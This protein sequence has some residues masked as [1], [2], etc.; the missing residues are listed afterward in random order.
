MGQITTGIGLISGINTADIIDQL[1]A[2][3][4][5]PKELVQQQNA[6]LTAQ[7]AAFQSISARLLGL[8]LSVGTLASTDIFGS[9]AASSSNESVITASSTNSAVPGSYS[10]TVDRLVSTQ[11]V[12]TNGFVDQN[13]TPIVTSGGT[14]TFEFGDARLDSNR[15]LSQLNG[16]NGIQRG[17]ISIT[18]RNGDTAVVDLSK[19]L[20]LNDVLDAIN[21]TAGIDVTASAD[22]DSFKLTDTSGGG[23]SLSVTDAGPHA[24]TASL[25]L[26][27][28]A[29]GDALTGTAVNI[30]G[31]DLFLGALNDNNG[32]RIRT[33]L[34][35]LQITRRDGTTFNVNLDGVAD[36]GGVIDTINA[37]S[38][39]DVT[40]SITSDGK[41][42]QLVDTTG[43]TSSNLQVAAI[44]GSLA[45]NDLGLVMS[46]A[47]NTLVGNRPMAELGSRLIKNLNGGSGVTT[48]GTIDLTNRTGATLV[49]LDLSSAQSVSDIIT[50]INNAGHSITASFNT[51]RNGVILTDTTGSTA[52]NL[53][54]A[55]NVGT[56]AT[57]L[58]LA[59]SVAATTIDSGNLQLRY[60]SEATTLAS[61]NGG[62][63]VASG[64]FTITDSSG[65]VATVD[66][67]QGD[68]TT[69]Q[70]VISEIN[71]RGLAINAR[72]NDNGDGILIEDTGT[73]VVKLK[74]EEFGSSTAKDL[75][76]L[77][78]ATILGADLDGSFEKTVS[79]A[80]VQT[81]TGTTTLSSLNGGTGVNAEAG[82]DDLRFTVQDGTTYDLNLDGLTTITDLINAIST[83]TSGAVTATIDALETGLT[84]TDSTSGAATFKVEALNSSQGGSDLDI[85]K[86]DDDGN[87]I[88]SGGA[89]VEI[90]TL[91][92][93]VGKINDLGI[94]INATVINDGSSISPFRLS[95]QGAVAGE[96]GRFMFD[97]G[98][99]GFGASTL[100]EAQNAV[101]FF[102]S[103]DPA[104]A[105]AITSANNTLTSIVP[106]ATIDL[107][108][109]SDS[110]VTVTI[111]RDDGA[112]VSAAENFVSSF[113]DLVTTLDDL[114]SYEIETEVRGIL[115]GD[116]TVAN[117]RS[118]LFRLVNGK[119]ND[120]TSQFTALT[121]IGL[122]IS[123]G[124]QMRFDETKFRNALSTDFSALEQLFTFK[125]TVTDP[126][127]LEVTLTAGGIMVRFED[128][129]EK[130]N[131]TTSGTIQNRFDSIQ[132]QID[133]GNQ[134]I[135]QFDIQLQSKRERLEFEFLSMELALAQLQ[136]QNSA[137]AGLQSL[138]A[139]V[140]NNN[141]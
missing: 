36:L 111:S 51:V 4:S 18:D 59:S 75:G 100:V 70:S 37:A 12:V 113:N 83:A 1:I 135:E 38:G 139:S 92:D 8:E 25:G 10:F 19:A 131:D 97:D 47:A 32:V 118:S 126:D 65:A 101:A 53:E 138:A 67:T 45:A 119:N 15:Q 76:L 89:I 64:Q 68:E 16:G 108:G 2:I 136:S 3:E 124:A 34:D 129:L 26:N 94:N 33:G 109:T 6:N 13:V 66:L 117:V 110:P 73:G 82:L 50:L 39:G 105:I 85:L 11:Q 120:V 7:Q 86:T 20:T 122:T 121:Q 22:G 61:L 17:K 69:V 5:R 35:D 42:L 133:L 99:L 27:V 104:V 31:R 29:V 63:G 115:L 90:T 128:L 9:T 28:T 95:L 71:S 112:I 54:V 140:N 41:A 123:G 137:L 134:R 78:E 24:T 79:I 132:N 72:I 93:L 30:L 130:L 44:N 62:L 14:L 40:A 84:L 55:D 52:S 107:I 48:L 23:G 80:S 96:S 46:V 57:D 43:S 81:L 56:T 91:Q 87:G 116:G 21:T 114:D 49:G 58:G 74:V 102:G 77:G 98:G 88:L 125:E 103:S 60:I 106:G 127:T 141:N